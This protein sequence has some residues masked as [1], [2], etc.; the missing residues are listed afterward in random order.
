MEYQKK[1]HINPEGSPQVNQ[2]KQLQTNNLP[3]MMWKIFTAQIKEEI[4]YSVIIRAN[5]SARAR[6]IF[7]RSLTSLNSEFLHLGYLPHQGWRTQSALLFTH[8]WRENI[9]IH[10]F[11]KGISFMWNA[12][13]LVQDL[14]SY[15]RVHF[16]RHE[17][18]WW[19]RWSPGRCARYFN[20]T[21]RTNG[22]CKHII[23]PREWHT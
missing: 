5:P 16:L 9:W 21:I 17:M 10:T 4:Y 23:C 12:I 15:R 6:S 18:T 14:N 11:P 13:S 3:T 20:S 19:V 2:P 1:D 8:S 7:K 22:I